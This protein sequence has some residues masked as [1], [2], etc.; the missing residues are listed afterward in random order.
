[1]TVEE[2]RSKKLEMTQKLRN[3]VSDKAKDGEV[4]KDDEIQGGEIHPVFSNE[5]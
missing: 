1:M 3:M 4:V 5:N 2:V